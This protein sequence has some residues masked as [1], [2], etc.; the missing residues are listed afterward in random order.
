MPPEIDPFGIAN[1]L[2][3]GQ[4]NPLA[5]DP[6]ARAVAYARVFD[7]PEGRIVFADMAERY[8]RRLFHLGAEDGRRRTDF[9]LGQNALLDDIRMQIARA[10]F[11]MPDESP[12]QER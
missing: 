6:M 10:R 1:P 11:G 8:G 4:R 12:E 9:A 2:G 3:G 5:E 7:S